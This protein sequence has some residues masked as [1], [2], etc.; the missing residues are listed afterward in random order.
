[1]LFCD[2][3]QKILMN[4][5]ALIQSFDGDFFI[6]TNIDI[7]FLRDS[8]NLNENIQEKS[9]TDH[10]LLYKP[11]FFHSDS[12][13]IVSFNNCLN[14]SR[15]KLQDHLLLFIQQNH[16]QKFVS[17]SSW[18]RPNHS[19]F[20]S[21][22]NRIK[23]QIKNGSIDKAVVMTSEKNTWIPNFIDRARLILNLLQNCPSHLF[24]YS[25]WDHQ[26]G[27]VIGASPEYLFYRNDHQ[28][29]SMALAGTLA[30]ETSLKENFDSKK[31][32]KTESMKLFNGKIPDLDF[33]TSHLL[34]NSKEVQEH[35]YV[36]EDLMEKFAEFEVQA[37]ADSLEVIEFP[38]L[39]HLQTKIY[40]EINKLLISND[41]DFALTHKLHP[42]SALGLRSKKLH[43]HWLK[44]LYGHRDLGHYGAPVGFQ[45]YGGFFC[46][47]GIRNL[48]WDQFGT[49]L[50]AGCGII[51]QSRLESE[52]LELEAKRESVKSLLGLI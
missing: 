48:E 35:Q 29:H 10:P 50:R 3:F 24:I 49:Y 34:N 27:G 4:P 5:G 11:T 40:G 14:F 19:Y 7:Q 52:W 20:Q 31:P 22:F 45:L 26:G 51:A 17:S 23:D 2:A 9:S 16:P 15:K 41:F 25:H 39:F 43:W 37:K 38:H 33:A 18:E 44:E 28:I 47:V 30:K 42:S 13:S 8:T 21:D 12:T 6:F 46:L 1:M 36:V 32:D